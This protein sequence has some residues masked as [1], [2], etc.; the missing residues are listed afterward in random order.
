MPAAAGWKSPEP[1]VA[2]TVLAI[3]QRTST[4]AVCARNPVGG[5]VRM[6]ACQGREELRS[7][8]S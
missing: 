8:D 1:A 4:L 2:V 6:G 5:Q 3:M 7:N